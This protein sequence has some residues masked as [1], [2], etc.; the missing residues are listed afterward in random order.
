MSKNTWQGG[1]RFWMKS[2]KLKTKE[3]RKLLAVAGANLSM[4]V[5]SFE[6]WFSLL[7]TNLHL[8]LFTHSRFTSPPPPQILTFVC[9]GNNFCPS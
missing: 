7:L 8:L 9:S 5:T 1:K 6:D 2:K 3:W 4:G